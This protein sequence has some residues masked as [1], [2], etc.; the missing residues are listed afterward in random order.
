MQAREHKDSKSA[1]LARKSEHPALQNR[2]RD[3]GRCTSVV[4]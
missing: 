4:C 3:R 2:A 1:S